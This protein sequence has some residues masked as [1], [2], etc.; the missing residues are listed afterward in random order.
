M[1]PIAYRYDDFVR[2]ALQNARET[3]LHGV[4]RDHGPQRYNLL[5]AVASTLQSVRIL[6]QKMVCVCI[7][8]LTELS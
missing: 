8:D 3:S 5:L 7:Y 4:W 2:L 6:L 1:L